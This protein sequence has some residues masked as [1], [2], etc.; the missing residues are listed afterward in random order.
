MIVDGTIAKNGFDK[1]YTR[2]LILANIL[3]GFAFASI[4][5][6][7]SYIV[8]LIPSTLS[9]MLFVLAVSL[10]T[11]WG[12]FDI[13]VKLVESVRLYRSFRKADLVA[14]RLLEKNGLSGD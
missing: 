8:M 9:N 6:K 7:V 1:G 13:L 4:F 12:I 3:F 10:I 11:G 2:T 14:K 5:G